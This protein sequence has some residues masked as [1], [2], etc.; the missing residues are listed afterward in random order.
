[1]NNLDLGDI[2]PWIFPKVTLTD[3]L[4]F[5]S[6]FLVSVIKCF[7]CST[8]PHLKTDNT[9]LFFSKSFLDWC[10]A[11]ESR[12]DISSSMY[13]KSVSYD[14]CQKDHHRWPTSLIYSHCCNLRQK[15]F[16]DKAN[17]LQNISSNCGPLSPRQ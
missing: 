10:L 15:T 8:L 17:Y 14:G 4:L 6:S 9:S 11:D 5:I 13:F 16:Y 12:R 7:C 1:M 2:L 3:C